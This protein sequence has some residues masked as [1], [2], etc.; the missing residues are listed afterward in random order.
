MLFPRLLVFPFNN[1]LHTDK[2]RQPADK[3]DTAGEEVRHAPTG[4]VQVELMGT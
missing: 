4:T 1:P 3:R 2:V